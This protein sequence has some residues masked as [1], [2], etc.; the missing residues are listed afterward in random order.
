M[1]TIPTIDPN[2]QSAKNTLVAK[3]LTSPSQPIGTPP[4]PKVVVP[5][6]TSIGFGLPSALGSDATSPQIAVFVEDV[7]DGELEAIYSQVKVELGSMP[8][9]LLRAGR[10]T[11]QA[12]P[13]GPGS[14][15][16]SFAPF[17]YNVPQITAGTFGAVVEDAAGTQYI[18]GSNHVMAYNGR[19]PDGTPIVAPGTLDDEN[20]FTV[21]GKRSGFVELHPAAWPVTQAQGPANLNTVDCA[22]AEL[23]AAG[24]AKMGALSPAIAAKD[25]VMTDVHKTGRTTGLTQGSVCVIDCEG[26]IDLSFGTFYFKHL[27]GVLG[28]GPGPFAAPGDSGAVVVEDN[29]GGAVGM[30]MARVYSSGGFIP[31][32]QGPPAGPFE[33]YIVL[34]CSMVEVCSQLGVQQNLI[35]L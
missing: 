23:T 5:L 15:I 20:T 35:V 7:S 3:F 22:L 27:N 10:F 34:M 16:S 11:G 30:V 4:P 24:K 28:K 33:G 8:F 13:V 17:R 26:F 12:A 6:V 31:N 29:G 2:I 21:I 14:S 25:P 19:A 18:L 9:A 32:A 1:P